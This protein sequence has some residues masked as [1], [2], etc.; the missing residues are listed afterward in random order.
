MWG[1]M[2]SFGAR[3][4]QVQEFH[5]SRA[6]LIVLIN[7]VW[8]LLN[9]EKPNPSPHECVNKSE[10]NHFKYLPFQTLK[11]GN[12]WKI[13]RIQSVIPGL[14]QTVVETQIDE[15]RRGLLYSAK[16]NRHSKRMIAIPQL[17]VRKHVSSNY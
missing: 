17:Q 2:I 4:R 1:T 13:D 15:E 8:L 12:M 3:P 14:S 16:M 7:I 10:M 6:C 9:P 11:L 5:Q